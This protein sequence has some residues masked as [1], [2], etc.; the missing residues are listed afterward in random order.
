MAR[1]KE[2]VST[3]SIILVFAA[4]FVGYMVY[5]TT[6]NPIVAAEN[7]FDTA[8]SF[9]PSDAANILRQLPGKLTDIFYRFVEE[10]ERNLA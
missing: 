1:K 2:S 10:L 8:L 7:L 4:L 5:T 6:Y 3:T 9:L